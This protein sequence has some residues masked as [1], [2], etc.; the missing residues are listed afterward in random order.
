M[1]S[2]S[3]WVVVVALAGLLLQHG[4]APD[5]V[6]EPLPPTIAEL[7]RSEASAE[8]PVG[9]PAPGVLLA[10]TVGERGDLHPC[11]CPDGVVG[12]VARRAAFVAEL[13]RH[14]TA[15]VVAAGPG[16]LASAPGESAAGA[17]AAARLAR[18]LDIHAAAGAGV[19]AL[20]ASD[21]AP[22]EPSALVSVAAASP[23]P[24]VATNIAGDA[25]DPLRA[26][27]VVET[28]AGRLAILSLIDPAAAA[29]Q[30]RGYRVAPVAEAV[31]SALA[32]L[33]PPAD[34][35]IA[36]SDASPRRLA[37]IAP[38]VHGV[39]FFV[40]AA[41]GEGRSRTEVERGRHLVLLEPGSMRVGL[42]DMLFVGAP[43][44]EFVE[45]RLADVAE[46][47]LVTLAG[48]IRDDLTGQSPL[49]VGLA[50]PAEERIVTLGGEL[51]TGAAEGNVAGFHAAPMLSIMP[52]D[53][54]V[55]ARIRQR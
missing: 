22:V 3:P 9:Q 44:G 38:A 32:G 5:P 31:D 54:T 45:D 48:L 35:V 52:E 21:L 26:V 42:L 34:L 20:G 14:V 4:C 50:R 30:P 2:R 55:A 40:G 28:A 12:G 23:V 16:T 10:F 53:A 47:R 1:A 19:V 13:N 43:G 33:E 49:L 41:A 6:A 7:E 24:L 11:A 39:H 29:L 8:A 51:L 36:F 18:L 27:H 15:P 37:E 25:L 46:Q 17:E